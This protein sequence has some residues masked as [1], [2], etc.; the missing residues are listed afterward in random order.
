[1]LEFWNKAPWIFCANPDVGDRLK[2][3][4]LEHQGVEL[5]FDGKGHRIDFQDLVGKSI[6]VYAQQ[7]VLK[8][9]IV[10]R[11]SYHAPLFFEAEA[12]RIEDCDTAPKIHYQRDGQKSRDYL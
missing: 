2:R 7:E 4:G 12:M 8:D 11:L 3:E 6:T 10:S 5:R 9:L 1:M